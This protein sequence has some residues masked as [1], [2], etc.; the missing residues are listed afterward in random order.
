MFATHSEFRVALQPTGVYLLRQ[1][2]TAAW[3]LGYCVRVPKPGF[4]N[5]GSGS[6]TEVPARW[7]CSTSVPSRLLGDTRRGGGR[8]DGGSGIGQSGAAAEGGMH[9]ADALSRGGRTRA[10][11]ARGTRAPG[12]PILPGEID[13][14]SL[15]AHEVSSTWPSQRS[16]Q[17]NR[18]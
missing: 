12:C 16:S 14:S 13:G 6:G 15:G 10:A 17:R 7:S 11:P 5:P 2:V 9:S 8:V 1:R 18:R 4:R 3:P